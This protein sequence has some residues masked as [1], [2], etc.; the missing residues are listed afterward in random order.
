MINKIKLLIISSAIFILASCD[1]NGIKGISSH[2]ILIYNI[3][4]N[5]MTE[6]VEDIAG[7]SNGIKVTSNQLNSIDG[8]SGAVNGK[9]YTEGL[10][11]GTF[12][13]KKSPTPTEIQTVIDSVNAK[14][15]IINTLPI[16]KVNV[17]KTTAVFGDI[18]S[19]NS[20]GSTDS[21]GTISTYKWSDG[22]TILSN[23][24]SFSISTLTNGTHTITLTI[25]DNK[26]AS[27]SATI[28]IT[29]TNSKPIAKVNVNKTTAIFGDILSFNSNGSG[30]SDGTIS[31]YKWSDGATILSNSSSFSIS[32]LTNGTHT[33]TLTIT[34]NKNA[35]S[36]ATISI[37]ITNAQPIAKANVNKTT[38]IFGDILSFNSNGSGD[39]DG[40]ISTY[41]WS[42]G[43]TIL[44][45]S[46][47]FSISTLTNGTHTITLTITDNKNAS[48]SDNITITIT[49]A[50]PIARANV[51]KTTAV[52]GDTLSFNSN[53]STD[54][55]GT[56]STYKWSDGATIL[57][58]SSSFSI[59]T[60]TNGTH[61]ITLTITDNKSASSSANLTITI[62]PNTP[63]IARA[64]V[65][66]T[67]A[68]FGDSLSFN[69]NGSTDSDGTI[70]TYKWNEGATILSNSSSF[71]ISTLTNGTHTITLTITD[72]KSASS[73]DNITISINPNTPPIVKAYVDK[74][75]SAYGLANSI[76]FD[77]NGSIDND[78]TIISFK[79]IEKNITLSTN[80]SFSINTF[81]VGKHTIILT[82]TDNKNASS[83]AELNITIRSLVKKTGQTTQ[84]VNYDDGHYQKGIAHSYTRDNTKEVVVDNTT[85]LM[86]QDNIDAKTIQKQWITTINYNAGN[87]TNTLGD[88]ASTYCN[89]LT[90]GGFNDWRLSTR[91]ELLSIIDYS[92]STLII[93]S[94]FINSTNNYY[95]CGTTH[96]NIP[97]SA[98]IIYFKYGN[99]RYNRK[100]ST[101]YVRCIR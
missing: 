66:K 70:S 97:D 60:L 39:S 89:N 36:L 40:T 95:W 74:P 27:S 76:L 41:K 49:N 16:V 96:A 64:N 90:L 11:K 32:T 75:L 62:N 68:V 58:N 50:Q 33:I 78:G 84:F 18:L 63:P 85:G 55:D 24:S 23:S 93:N 92:K 43:A 67:I 100:D 94:A 14:F 46:S 7:N 28:S 69:S 52:F 83:T 6:I 2:T 13:D 98:W 4:D 57:S 82:V 101:Y 15:K 56:I 20:N 10:I 54:S 81:S 48:S 9:D 61:T 35:S 77:S 31:T 45:N 72:N 19:F 71:S 38:A 17:N 1:G 21:D 29:I 42:D 47:S 3:V 80:A 65:D 79:W 37:T 25:T 51:D 99:T 34:D 91:E 44:S 22:A 8:V 5:N 59:S 53:G 87:Y 88:T 12:T 26:N 30:D 73:S 86:W